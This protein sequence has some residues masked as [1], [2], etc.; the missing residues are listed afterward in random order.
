MKFNAETIESIGGD[1]TDG[2]SIFQASAES[3]GLDGLSCEDSHRLF[4]LYPTRLHV[5][6]E[7]GKV[8]GLPRASADNAARQSAGV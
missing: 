5:D 3:D 8:V 1:R 4:T 2:G 6:T 7:S